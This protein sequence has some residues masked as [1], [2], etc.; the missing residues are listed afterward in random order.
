[1][2]F[3]DN[4]GDII[5]DA[6][7]TDTGRRRL[8]EGKFSI[9]Q[10]AL[11]DDE[12]NYASYD[13][14]NPSGSAYYDLQILQ[15]P[16]FEAFTNNASSMKSKILTITNP[17]LL[18]LPV[19]KL[20]A[21]QAQYQRRSA[22]AS[23]G[24]NTFLVIADKTTQD[25]FNDAAYDYTANGIIAGAGDAPTDVSGVE[26]RFDQ[27]LD[28]NALS[29]DLPLAAELMEDSFVI[30]MDDRLGTIVKNGTRDAPAPSAVDDDNI[31][32]YIVDEG[33]AIGM[34]SDLSI[35][36]DASSVAIAGSR[37]STLSFQIMAKQI[38]ADSN[39]YFT[40]FGAT[41]AAADFGGDVGSKSVRFIDT[42]VTVYGS[43]TGYTVQIPIR[44][45]KL[46]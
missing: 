44:Y 43:N 35:T 7:L 29:V 5:L 42:I 26:I 18:Y 46:S 19:I 22:G 33:D 30:Q 45:F 24:A 3:L 14:N 41:E 23:F 9:S 36:E 15:T 11:G 8:A 34:V 13:K 39:Y 37:G 38:L 20:N 32:T 4:S 6:V 16:V 31:A 2:A 21:K 10:F 12:I 27:G 1:M 40:L 17:N 25:T 28:T